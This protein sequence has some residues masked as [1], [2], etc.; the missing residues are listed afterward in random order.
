[1]YCFIITTNYLAT[2][3]FLLHS[4]QHALTS[5][6]SYTHFTAKYEHTLKISSHKCR[7]L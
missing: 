1:M 3:R 2:E 5:S 4:F 6:T 7:I